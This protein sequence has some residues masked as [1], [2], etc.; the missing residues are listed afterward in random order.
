MTFILHEAI[1][2]ASAVL[3]TLPIS[4]IAGIG[5]A[6]SGLPIGLLIAVINETRDA[7]R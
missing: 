5:L 1:A 7:L 4:T 3:S 6:T 2:H